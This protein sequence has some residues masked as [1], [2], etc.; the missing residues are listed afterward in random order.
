[1][2]STWNSNLLKIKKVLASYCIFGPMVDDTF[3][4]GVLRF[5]L[6]L[7]KLYGLKL[8]VIKILFI[9]IYISG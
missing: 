5:F 1:M 7:V 6:M 3:L 8:V 9:T 2:H 4:H